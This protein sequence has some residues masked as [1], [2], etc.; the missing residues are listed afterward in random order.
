MQTKHTDTPNLYTCY[1]H[2]VSFTAQSSLRRHFRRLH[3]PDEGRESEAMNVE[4]V[5][6]G[7]DLEAIKVEQADEEEE[8]DNEA[9]AQ[10]QNE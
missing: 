10:K 9:E 8:T 1:I 6:E 7:G 5:D 3:Q 4:Q 2:N